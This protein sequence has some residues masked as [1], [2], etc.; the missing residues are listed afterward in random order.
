MPTPAKNAKAR[1][2]AAQLETD[3]ASARLKHDVAVARAWVARHRTACIVAGGFIGGIA[4]SSLSPRL[5]SRF[6]AVA[7][8]GAAALA[9]S[10][11]TPMIAGAFLARRS[12]DA[13]QAPEP[14][15]APVVH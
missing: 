15:R 7:G 4:L 11:L 1:L 14:V 5:W 6:G 2:R 13:P 10:L 3:A 12:A 9:R 8:A